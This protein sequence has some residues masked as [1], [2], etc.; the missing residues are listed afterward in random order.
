M[1]KCVL[2]VP[3]RFGV[4]ICSVGMTFLIKIDVMGLKTGCDLSLFTK[5][6]PDLFYSSLYNKAGLSSALSG[7]LP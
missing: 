3:R 7:D 2:P 5:T 1:Q 4:Q 6:S